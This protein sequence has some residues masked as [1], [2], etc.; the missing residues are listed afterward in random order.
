MAGAYIGVGGVA[1]KMKNQYLGVG[2]V[3]RKVK[4]GF[5]GVGGV[6]RKFFSAVESPFYIY[7]AGTWH[8]ALNAAGATD[9]TDKGTYLQQ[10]GSTTVKL[11]AAI[12]VTDYNNAYVKVA[13]N[14]SGDCRQIL[15]LYD[16]S[17]T[18]VYDSEVSGGTKTSSYWTAAFD[19]SSVTGSVKIRLLAYSV[20]NSSTNSYGN[21]YYSQIYLTE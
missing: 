18:K 19:I 15:R 12:D 2:S 8:S 4:N 20:I 7:N 5:A 14:G 3:A 16:T 11:N 13:T 9:A 1:R 10:N 6:A 17:G 21:S